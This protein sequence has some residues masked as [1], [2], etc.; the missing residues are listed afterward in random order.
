MSSAG[1][2]AVEL[3]VVLSFVGPG[4]KALMT[5]AAAEE[6]L[7]LAHGL[8]EVFVEVVD[9]LRDAVDELRSVH[10]EDDVFEVREAGLAK[11]VGESQL[12]IRS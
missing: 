6:Q 9:D 7:V 10:R 11:V 12:P 2:V 1:A 8:D 3:D 4:A 5:V